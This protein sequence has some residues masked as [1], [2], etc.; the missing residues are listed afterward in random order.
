VLELSFAEEEDRWELGMAWRSNFTA[1]GV[2]GRGWKRD[3]E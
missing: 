2:F 1:G 3:N